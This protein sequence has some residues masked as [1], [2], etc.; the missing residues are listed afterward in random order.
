[1][2]LI[3]K[4]YRLSSA[5]DFVTSS[6]QAKKPTSLTS[7]SVLIVG[8]VNSDV[9]LVRLL[10]LAQYLHFLLTYLVLQSVLSSLLTLNAFRPW[11]SQAVALA[12]MIPTQ[13]LMSTFH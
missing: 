13:M 4:L 9:R 7:D 2:L 11:E 12:P 1:M 8:I 10:V 5:F 3:V 6:Y